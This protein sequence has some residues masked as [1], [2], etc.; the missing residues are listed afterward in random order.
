MK[1]KRQQERERDTHTE[2][3]E[4]KGFDLYRLPTKKEYHQMNMNC[5]TMSIQSDIWLSSL[6]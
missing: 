6:Q 1:I 4:A 3:N 5:S 2:E